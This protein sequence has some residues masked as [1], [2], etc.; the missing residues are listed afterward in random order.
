[1]QIESILPVNLRDDHGNGLL[2]VGNIKDYLND[3]SI[4]VSFK[5]INVN[6]HLFFVEAILIFSR[7][8]LTSI[9]Q[10]YGIYW[11]M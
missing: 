1:M 9:S 7:R 3:L 8:I 4:R 2:S 11:R 5:D 6:L 10:I